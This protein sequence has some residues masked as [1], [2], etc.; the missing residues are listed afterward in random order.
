MDRPEVLA[1]ITEIRRQE[2]DAAREI[3]GV[4]QDWLGFVDSGWPEGDP[5]PPLPEGC[6]GLMDAAGR[7]RAAGAVDAV[8]PAARGHDVRR[9][10]WL[11]APRPHPVPQRVRGGVRGGRRPDQ[12]PGRRGALAAAEALL[13]PRLPPRADPGA[14]R[15]DGPARHGVAVRRTAGRVEARPGARRT[16]HHEGP[17]CGV[18]PDPRPG[19]ARARHP[20]RP[21]GA[22]VQLPVAT[23][24]R[25]RGPPRTTSWRGRSSTTDLPEYDLFAG[26]RDRAD[27]AT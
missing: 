19:A 2:M 8:V 13:P 6:F 4:R 17:V 25:R 12:V 14:A 11:P 7:R 9:E 10:R 27:L 16:G 24:T 23:C 5:Q 18:L 22:V 3:L 26:V 21:R 20:D 1:N 15:R